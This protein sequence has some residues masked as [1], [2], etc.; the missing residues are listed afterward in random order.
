MTLKLYTFIFSIALLVLTG[1][2]SAEK[3]Y[4]QGRYDEAVEAAAKKLSKKPGDASLQQLIQEAYRYAVND[5][6]SRIRDLSNGS[7]ALRW[8]KIYGEYVDLQRLYNSI[9]GNTAVFELVQPTDYSSYI[10]TYK[11]EAGN[12][13]FERGM[14]MMEQNTKKGFRD[15]YAEFQKALNLKPGDLA[16][17]QKMDEAYANA[18]TNVVIQPLTRYGF[19]YSNY[20]FDYNNF[21]YNL[22]RYLDNNS[23]GRFLDFF[24]PSEASANRMRVDNYV[25]LH[26]N[27]VNIGR[28]RD[29]RSVREVSK[30]IVAKEIVYS[31]D[32]V[33]KEYITVRAKVTT[34]TRT[35]NANGLL[36]AT[37][38]DYNNRYI[39]SD[40]YNGEY[41]W[42][43]T[44]A[45]FTGDE[46]ALSEEDKRQINRREEWPPSND[47]IIRFIM[48]EVQ[49][50][51]QTGLANY[52][53]SYY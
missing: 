7:S 23:S 41:R 14:Q 30:Q 39:W 25:D 17:R 4:S 20:A 2:K 29:Q 27:D 45:S 36:Q 32:S 15:A 26:F 9:R 53:S 51:T 5:H 38:R 19:Q 8:E 22:L 16:I 42:V 13:R 40:T 11:E 6:E 34:T 28:Y 43:T 10:A 48:N 46:R 31:K 37:V 50:K 52:F 35:M 3:L 21:N 44:F 33:V 12:A 49:N 47:D 18:V 1:C 24:S